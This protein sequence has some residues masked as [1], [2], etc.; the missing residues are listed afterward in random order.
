MDQPNLVTL[1]VEIALLIAEE[2]ATCQ[3]VLSLM[4]VYLDS[5]DQSQ[6]P[7]R[8]FQRIMFRMDSRTLLP[9]ALAQRP[10]FMFELGLGWAILKGD[11]TLTRLA[12]TEYQCMDSGVVKRL[13]KTKKDEPRALKFSL[14]PFF[15]TRNQAKLSDPTPEMLA[16]LSGNIEMLRLVLETWVKGGN[17]MGRIDEERKCMIQCPKGTKD[18][19]FEERI[20]GLSAIT[21]AAYQGRLDMVQLL[22][23]K[24]ATAHWTQQDPWGIISGTYDSDS[25]SETWAKY[26]VFDSDCRYPYGGKYDFDVIASICDWGL[27]LHICEKQQSARME[28]L[29][30]FLDKSHP[31]AIDGI[32]HVLDRVRRGECFHSTN[33]LP[34]FLTPLYYTTWALKPEF[35]PHA[36][37]LIRRGAKWA[38]WTAWEHMPWGRGRICLPGWRPNWAMSPLEWVLRGGVCGACKKDQTEPDPA[39]LEVEQTLF[40]TMM[41]EGVEKPTTP[42]QLQSALEIVIHAHT[43]RA[44]R[45][46]PLLRDLCQS[47]V[48]YLVEKGARLEDLDED[49]SKAMK[50]L[51][52]LWDKDLS[53]LASLQT[54]SQT[55]PGD[56]VEAAAECAQSTEITSNSGV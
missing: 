14:C 56:S 33:Y 20:V 31:F 23:D 24:G 10:L 25:D 28:V 41:E 42:E 22:I 2:L 43:N 1:P 49:F 40:K 8:P 55:E 37:L 46:H 54:G 36:Q 30:Y 3:D 34:G 17:K 39:Q 9:E 35:V 48:R 21:L 51:G 26:V 19:E 47:R 27:D 13:W 38:P 45:R 4:R 52:R 18:S 44:F 15:P 5:K 11:I 32:G 50:K 6:E 29:R 16:V 12:L 7:Q 53:I